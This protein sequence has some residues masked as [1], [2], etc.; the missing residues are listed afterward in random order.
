MKTNKFWLVV[1]LGAALAVC[2][3]T[4]CEKDNYELPEVIESEVSDSGIDETVTETVN[5]EGGV[6][7]SYK[8]WIQVQGQTRASFDNRVEATLRGKLA[9][10]SR[11]VEVANWHFGDK[12]ETFVTRRAGESRK[13]GFVTITDS[14]LV[15]TVKYENFELAFE[16]PFEVA[17][18]DDGFTRQVMPYYYY[19]NLQDRGGKIENMDSG[20]DEGFAYAQK[21]YTHTIAVDFNGKTYEVTADVLLRRKLGPADEPYIVNSSLLSYGISPDETGYA[22]S[23]LVVKQK[24]STGEEVDRNYVINLGAVIHSEVLHWVEIGA[25]GGDLA[26]VSA[27]LNEGVKSPRTTEEKFLSSFMVEQDYVVKYNYFTIT[28]QVAH[29]EAVYDD[30]VSEFD[31]PC[32]DFEKLENSFSF[33]KGNAGEDE[34]GAYQ[35][36]TLRHTVK[37]SLADGGISK[38]GT[39]RMNVMSR[40]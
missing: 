37:A 11:E 17:V 8:T 33:E 15:Y 2:G 32:Y 29:D 26:I 4:S 36:Y 23:M 38:E 27:E 35:W 18:Y 7:L 22:L 20:E 5:E 16:L 6:S 1:A 39:V 3:L 9:D 12:P 13:D 10:F 24:W 19:S 30:G 14:L 21:R 31:F 40:P 28:V 25:Y 34:N